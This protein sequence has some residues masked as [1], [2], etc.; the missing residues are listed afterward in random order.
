MSQHN[1]R[2]IGIRRLTQFLESWMYATNINNMQF[3]TALGLCWRR[4]N[5]PR[6]PMTARESNSVHVSDSDP[7]EYSHHQVGFM[8]IS[9][10][11]ARDDVASIADRAR[12]IGYGAV[13]MECVNAPK[14]HNLNVASNLK[15]F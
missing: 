12:N 2:K 10:Q 7:R 8:Q 5:V 14:R 3:P 11:L 4:A 1:D 9:S 15:S 6:Q 13:S